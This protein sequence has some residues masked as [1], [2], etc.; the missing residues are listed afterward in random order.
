MSSACS[1]EP[2]PRGTGFSREPRLQ[3]QLI[4]C[5]AKCMRVAATLGQAPQ[6]GEHPS[7]PSHTT[8]REVGAGDSGTPIMG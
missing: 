1:V 5:S 4:S 8:A 6:A 7:C 3:T 2:F